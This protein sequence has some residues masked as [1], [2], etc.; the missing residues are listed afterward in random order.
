MISYHSTK[1]EVRS[2][3]PTS[4]QPREGAKMKKLMKAARSVTALVS[5]FALIILMS[6]FGSL[7]RVV[8]SAPLL[9]PASN[10]TVF[11]TGL[12]NPRGLKFGPDGNLYVAEGGTGGTHST[13]GTCP[14]APFPVGPYTGSN[15]GGRISRIDQQGNRTTVIDTLPSSQTGPAL[16]GLVSGVADV[17]FIGD[18]LYALLAGAGCSHGVTSLPNGIVRINPIGPPTLIANLSAFQQANPVANPEPDDF[19]PDGTWYS[20]VVVDGDFYAVEPNHGEVDR[21]TLGGQITRVV[22]VSAS[23]GHIVPTSLT[24]KGNF[25]FG[26]LGTFP[27]TPGTQRIMKLTPSGQLKSWETGLTTVLGLAFDG[28]DRLYALE[29][30]TN[31]GFPS[32]A[33]VGSGRVVRIDP[34]GTQTVIATGLSFPTAMTF[35]PDGNLYVSNFGFAAGIGQIVRI[36][37]PRESKNSIHATSLTEQARPIV[38]AQQSTP[39]SAAEP[40]SSIF[41]PLLQSGGETSAATDDQA[42]QRLATKNLSEDADVASVSV[43][44]SEA[45]AVLTGNVTSAAA[46]AKAEKFVKAVQGVKAIDNKIVVL[47]Q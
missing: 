21:I 24:Y 2:V 9:T 32:P 20:M 10:V 23:Q 28:R 18:Q 26:N 16:G 30:M 47:R 1:L 39:A 11:A 44:I 4:V 34:N 14:Q 7:K 8:A 5:L 36:E 25:F 43:S 38:T 13:V 17:A 37:V 29:S 31:P 42:L 19:E 45:R 33:Q 6:P 12:N 35:G 46:K 22:D 27:V 40:A 41:Y 3:S 15:T